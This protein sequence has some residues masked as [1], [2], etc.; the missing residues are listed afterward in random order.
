MQYYWFKSF[1]KS[2]QPFLMATNCF[3]TLVTYQFSF[4]K[5]FSIILAHNSQRFELLETT[6]YNYK[7]SLIILPFNFSF[8]WVFA[9]STPKFSIFFFFPSY[10]SQITV[11]QLLN[12]SNFATENSFNAKMWFMF[13]SKP[14]LFLVGKFQCVKAGIHFAS[15]N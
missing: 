14:L 8:Q 3:L 7:T 13:R 11:K 2:I 6:F 4:T 9:S 12:K 10:C 15:A 5:F 1:K